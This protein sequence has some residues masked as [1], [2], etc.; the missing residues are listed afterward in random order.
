MYGLAFTLISM[1]APAVHGAP[2]WSIF[3]DG[4]KLIEGTD[5]W[6]RSPAEL[7]RRQEPVLAEGTYLTPVAIGAIIGGVVV[8]IGLVVLLFFCGRGSILRRKRG[9]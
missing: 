6:P 5:E 1:S 8:T 4:P 3:H 7:Q 9:H 2:V